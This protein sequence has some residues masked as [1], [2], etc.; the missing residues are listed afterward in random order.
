[1]APATDTFSAKLRLV[2][3]QLNLSRVG[4]AHDIGVDKTVVGRWLSGVNEPTGHN[5]TLLTEIVRK[6]TPG[7]TLGRWRGS[8][9][10]VAEAVGAAPPAAPAGS[11][12]AAMPMVAA[13]SGAAVLALP[14]KPSIAVLP[15]L[16]MS[17][18]PEQEYFVD[19]MV[20]D[21]ITKLSRLR[22]LFV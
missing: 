7:F 15:F 4:L 1:M 21:L 14:D 5:L 16:N 13:G 11:A 18:D 20:E 9:A 8:L 3:D 10:D 19:G 2:M 6:R 17:S 22:W 12:A